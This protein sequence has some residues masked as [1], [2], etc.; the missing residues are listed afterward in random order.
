[1]NCR[2][3][4]TTFTALVCS[5]I[6]FADKPFRTNSPINAQSGQ[7]GDIV[8]LGDKM[9]HGGEWCE[10]LGSTRVQET[11]SGHNDLES[12]KDEIQA[13]FS[14]NVSPSMIYLHAGAAEAAQGMPL[15]TIEAR[16][17]R[18]VEA[19]KTAAPESRLVL[20]SIQPIYPS[21]REISDP[22]ELNK[23][24]EAIAQREGAGYVDIFTPM[25]KGIRA[26]N[27]YVNGNHVTEKGYI[28]IAR[29]LAESM[30]LSPVPIMYATGESAYT[31]RGNSA[32]TLT[33]LTVS[34]AQPVTLRKIKVVLNAVNGDVERISIV[35]NGNVL[36]SA[37]VR[38]RKSMYR[39]PCVMKIS[40]L[41]DIEVCADIALDA[42][43]G[44][45][46]SADIQ[47]VKLGRRWQEVPVHAAGER[48]IL[49]MR[50]KVLGQGWYGTTGY[51]IPAILS[52]PDGCI[53]ITSDDRKNNDLDL[54]E[55]IDIIAQR[56][57]DGG[58]TWSE[59]VKVIEGKGF[60][61]GYGDA[62]LEMSASGD[63]FCAFSGGV[64]LWAST[65]E[66]PQKNYISRSRDGGLTWEE[67]F[68]CT[69]ML[70]GPDAVNPECRDYHSAFFGSGHGLRLEKGEHAGRVLFVAAVHSEK[71]DRFD[72]YAFYTDD[73]GKTWHV[74]ERAF[75]GGDEAKVVELPDGRV[76]MSVRR[77]G[78]RGFNISEDGGQTWGEQGLWK[79]ICVNACDGDIINVG[80]SLLL[81]SVPN[82]MSRENVSVFVS[83]DN[84]QSWPYSKSL[85]KY[86]SV[87]S[88]MTV[89]PDGTIGAYIE[90]N[91]NVEFDMFYLNFSVDWLLKDEIKQ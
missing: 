45:R 7:Q 87:Y 91:P 37:K 74:S 55:D 48:E 68:D 5:T 51:R 41:E 30:G 15:D 49:L 17:S 18:L 77:T 3:L 75:I 90:E 13:I 27:R 43:E 53:L 14:S 2:Y 19:I 29:I 23:R 62:A 16:Y 57:T 73:N 42:K 84:G 32:E 72:N 38:A 39:I 4:I 67:P 54:P 86:E 64:G 47:R 88:S 60:N 69:S 26:E 65:L 8:M 89:L 28:K 1:M 81:H 34:P 76:M 6:M 36:G 83:R 12:I 44:D 59:P 33:T 10:L 25:C 63:I 11:G 78:E 52:L 66:N 40:G 61:K 35:S 71:L 56:S 70:W 80:D 85:C 82:S 79:D 24:I 9:I 50:T 21:H 22:I 46:V 58:R 20:M 31:G